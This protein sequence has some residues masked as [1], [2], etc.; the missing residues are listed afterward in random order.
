AD[1][2]A[3]RGMGLDVVRDKLLRVGG[4][5]AVRTRTGE[6]TTFT[7][8]IP[9]TTAIT[10]GLLFK[11]GAQV[12]A[13]SAAHVIE[14]VPLERAAPTLLTERSGEI[15]LLD[16]HA[17]LGCEPVA[18]RR[19]GIVVSFAERCFALGCDKLIGPRPIVVKSLGPLLA[20]LP[21]YAGATIS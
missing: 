4:D 6:G 16:L 1:P 20:P 3:G 2:V 13:I 15:P 18:P 12:Y 14:S 5:V 19:V 21:L 17:I 11:V 7:I 9:L 10:Q 8:R